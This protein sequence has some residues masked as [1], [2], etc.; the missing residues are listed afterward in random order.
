MVVLRPASVLNASGNNRSAP[1]RATIVPLL[2]RSR[3]LQI[4]Q[5]PGLAQRC[6]SVRL[7]RCQC[8]AGA[9]SECCATHDCEEEKRVPSGFIVSAG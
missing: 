8:R 5:Q 4:F 3:R 7:E 2:C 6:C 1:A 9:G